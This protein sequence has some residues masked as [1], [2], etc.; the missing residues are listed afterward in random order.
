[1]RGVVRGLILV[2]TVAMVGCKVV[3]HGAVVAD[4]NPRGWEPEEVITLRYENT[5]TT[6]SSSINIVARREYGKEATPLAV[7]VRVCA[8]DS[9]EVNDV[10]LLPTRGT[11]G[12][13]SFEEVEVLWVGNARL[14]AG[15]YRFF[16]SPQEPI[17]G[18]WNVGVEIE[19]RE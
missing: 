4:V 6:S 9:A 15:E 19:N 2:A 7:R 10:V 12:G 14:Q 1:M 8:P 13:G 11:K 18:L 3:P 5:D 16:L 17:K